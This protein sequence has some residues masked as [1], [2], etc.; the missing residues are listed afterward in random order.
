MY[1]NVSCH[2]FAN[3]IINPVIHVEEFCKRWPT[4]SPIPSFILLMSLEIKRKD[5]NNAKKA[6]KKHNMKRS[7]TYS[8]RRLLSSPDLVTSNQLMS[9]DNTEWKNVFR[10]LRV[11]LAAARTQN[12]TC[13][14]PQIK[15]A[16][17]IAA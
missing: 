7:T 4:L 15:T 8:V 3:A 11:C 6:K 13:T 16:A 1:T 2:P 17:P 5:F 14:Y 10:I 12:E 9:L